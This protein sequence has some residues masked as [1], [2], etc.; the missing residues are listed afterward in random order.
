MNVQYKCMDKQIDVWMDA[1]M[2][3]LMEKG[4][5]IG[6]CMDGLNDGKLVEWLKF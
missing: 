5:W 6:G 3:V 4:K 1:Q 2:D